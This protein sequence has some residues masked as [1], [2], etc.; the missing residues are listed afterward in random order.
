[1]IYL[2]GGAARAGKT[3]IAR[4]F[5]A[6]KAV[7]FLSLDYVMMGFVGGLP[8]YGVDSDADEREVGVK[9]W[10]LLENMVAA[11]VED[12]VDY[13]FEGAQLLPQQAAVLAQRFPGQIRECFVGYAQVDTQEKFTQLR[14]YGG[15]PDD[16]LKEYDDQRVAA[17]IERLK[18][19]SAAVE[20]T[21]RQYALA[22][23]EVPLDLEASVAM[24]LRH[25]AVI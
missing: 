25:W 10:P 21:C 4:R 2:L 19:Y 24:V 12:E 16:W 3:T 23:F 1:M 13:L 17:E 11:M 14:H 9:I 5:T 7:P 6:L 18:A 20:A 15:G 8:E 22:Y